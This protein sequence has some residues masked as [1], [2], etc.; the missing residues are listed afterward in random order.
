MYGLDND[1]RLTMTSFLKYGMDNINQYF[2]NVQALPSISKKI[3]GK[4]QSKL[5]LLLI[6]SLVL[7]G[8]D[9]KIGEDIIKE[10]SETNV[11]TWNR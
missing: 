3:I 6:Y 5:S 8:K 11:N 10:L 1:A 7:Q 4:Y 2:K 9:K